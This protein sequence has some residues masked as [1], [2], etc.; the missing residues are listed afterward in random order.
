MESNH[1]RSLKRWM[2]SGARW[3]LDRVSLGAAAGAKH[4]TP[5]WDLMSINLESLEIKMNERTC[6]VCINSTEF[7]GHGQS[8]VQ[9]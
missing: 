8:Q 4:S 1:R 7:L 5:R 6:V 9:S 3:P 2:A